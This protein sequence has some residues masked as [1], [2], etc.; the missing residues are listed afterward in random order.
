M[1]VNY[2]TSLDTFTNPTSSSSVANPSHSQQHADAND[3]IEALQSKVGTDNSAVTTSHD[4]RI[5][6]LELNPVTGT[7]KKIEQIVINN[8]GST[9]YKGQVVYASGSVGAS[10]KLRVTLSSNT[11]E[12][13]STKTFGI[14]AENIVNG[15]EGLLVSEGLLEDLDTTGANDGD[16]V[17]LGS[18]AGSKLYGLANKPSAPSHL[19]FLGIVVRGGNANNGSIFVKIQNGFELEE[20]HNV[21]ISSVADNQ[22]L[23]YDSTTGLWKNESIDSLFDPAG[24]AAAAL[25]DANDYTDIAVANLGNS[26]PTTYIPLSYYGNEDGV[27]TLDSAGFVPNT[28]LNIDARIQDTAAAII[29]DATHTNITATYDPVTKELSLAS[30]G[31]T[32]ADI[33]S[34]PP[35]SPNTGDFWLDADNAVLYIYDGQFWTEVSSGPIGPQGPAGAAGATGP[36]GAQGE[37]GFP[38]FLYDPRRAFANQYTAGEIIY[39]NGAYYICL[40]NNDAIPPTGGAIGVYWNPYSFGGGGG[41]GNF[42]LST[43]PPENPTEGDSW[44]DTANAKLYVYYDAFW[45][46]VVSPGPTGAEGPA[47]VNYQGNYNSA[48]SYTLHDGV[49]YQGSLWRLNE[50]NSPAGTVPSTPNWQKVVHKGDKGDTGEITIGTVTTV[51]D[52]NPATVTNVG[53]TT[54]AI[55][56]FQIP[57]GPRSTVEVGDVTTVSYGNPATVT[58]VGTSTDAVFDFELPGGPRST[59]Q[60]GTVSTGNYLSDVTVT[61]VGTTTDAIFNFSIPQGIPGNMHDFNV[62]ENPPTGAVEGLVW[63]NTTN[64]RAYVY[65]DNVWVEYAPGFVGERGPMFLNYQG[66]WDNT[67]E[68]VELDGVTHNGS[69]WVLNNQ[70]SVIGTPPSSPAWSLVVEKGATGE[71]SVGT[72]TNLVYGQNATVTNTGTST[73]AIFNFGIPAGPR[74]T[75]QIGNVDVV[76]FGTPAT[77]TNVGTES[78]AIFDFEISAGPRSTIDVGT[79]TTGTYSSSATV[80]NVGTESDAIFNFSIP[81]GIPGDFQPGLTPPANPLAGQVWYNTATGRAYVYHDSAWIE[82]SPG[83]VGPAGP[84]GVPTAQAVTS[85]ITMEAN[86]S[87]FVNTSAARTLTLPATPSLGDSLTIYDAYGSA[88]TNNITISRNGNKING[89]TE[90]AIIDVDQASSVF[91]YTGTTLGWRFD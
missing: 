35:V 10:G 64:G 40:A 22:V 44:F 33:S 56:N 81:Q 74:S 90:D 16:P 77:V 83:F 86:H 71:I 84:S 51:V 46:D 3:A 13:T 70:T 18:T 7:A 34:T 52:G 32:S 45:V 19:V 59:I 11:A 68:Y 61:N 65:Y 36:A 21:S 12:S 55:L 38:G 58:N 4:Y 49:T 62:G 24:S 88:A 87:Y 54:D 75:I 6:Q 73:D 25:L 28:Q 63:Y 85:N 78:D 8:T 26:L 57:A 43:T 42:T 53:T 89:Q 82:F 31:G 1:A 2:P 80:T 50:N 72:V 5:R 39:Y 60:V 29:T 69:L 47:F 20:L 67:E 41:S 15:G 37:I 14:L 91:V 48:V 23:R 66:T 17:W 30:T 27:A 79:V 76:P 9:L